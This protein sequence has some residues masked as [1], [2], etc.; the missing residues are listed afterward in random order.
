MTD[1]PLWTSEEVAE[2]LRVKRETVRGWARDGK[3]P[4]IK[5]QVG[6]RSDW[7]FVPEKIRNYVEKQSQA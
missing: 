4:A 2:F 1:E 6:R 3:I 5:L 7:R